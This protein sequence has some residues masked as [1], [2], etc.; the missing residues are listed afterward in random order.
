M[1]FNAVVKEKIAR[2][3]GDFFTTNQIVNVFDDANI[4]TDRELFAKWRIILD[5]FSK[6]SDQDAAIPHILSVFC[7]PLHFQD[8]Q[9]RS[10]FIE[11]LN[12]ILAYEN[13]K[14]QAT[15]KGAEILTDDGFPID[16]QLSEEKKSVETASK[17][18]PKT[19]ENREEESYYFENGMPHPGCALELFIARKILDRKTRPHFAAKELSFKQHSF[20]EICYIVNS[21]IEKGILSVFQ[22]TPEDLTYSYEE[23]EELFGEDEP[24][25]IK[26]SVVKRIE[27]DPKE[28]KWAGFDF[29]VEDEVKLRGIIDIGV[30]EFMNDK[31]YGDLGDLV[32]L[33]SLSSNELT[34]EQ[35]KDLVLRDIKNGTQNEVLINISDYLHPK[36]DIVRTLLS[37]DREGLL[38]IKEFSWEYRKNPHIDSSEDDNIKGFEDK[39]EVY[40]KVRL[41]QQPHTAQEIKITAMPELVVRSAED[42]TLTKGKKRIRLPKF[43]PT[44]WSKITIRFLDERNVLINAD[45]KEQVVSDYE[46]LGFADEKRGKP[47]LAWMFFYGLAQNNGET[48]PLP[49]PIPDNIKQQKRQLSD[50]LKTIF[51]NDTDPFYDPTETHTYKI[52]INLIPPQSDSENKD[53]LG[54]RKYLKETMTEEYEEPYNE[55]DR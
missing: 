17:P 8:P 45:K 37:M 22:Q 54:V 39:D 30:S 44:D 9:F 31:R 24:C 6:M 35:Q 16:V 2:T 46:A 53:T 55:H 27:K 3:I 28:L 40:A 48:K 25:V 41:I 5:A 7:H 10:N 15:N 47:N 29:D 33:S 14:I 43:K 20:A 26:W 23:C 51:K 34:Y 52:K 21:F 12:T 1:S 49:T 50:R 19:Q 18:K 4:P 13:L 38:R 11:E 32:D 36:V 42:N